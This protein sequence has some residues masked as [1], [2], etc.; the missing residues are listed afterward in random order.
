M[1]PFFNL[2]TIISRDGSKGFYR[3]VL[4]N[5]QKLLVNKCTSKDLLNF[6]LHFFNYFPFIY[7]F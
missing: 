6:H 5:N 1:A 2:K 7:Y 4:K 3:F